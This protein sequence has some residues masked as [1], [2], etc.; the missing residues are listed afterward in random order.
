MKRLV[1]HTRLVFGYP[2]RI[3]ALALLSTWGLFL[4]ACPEQQVRAPR[5][6]NG[7]VE[8]REECDDGNAVGGDGCSAYCTKEGGEICGNYED[9][10]HDGLADCADPDCQGNPVCF[11]PLENCH[12]SADDDDDGLID[13]DDP[14]C[15]QTSFC[16]PDED[17]TNGIDDDGNGLTDCQEPDC[18]KLPLCGAC[19][20]VKDLGGLE[21]GDATTVSLDPA[22]ALA[23]PALDC[24]PAG[25]LEMQVRLSL[26]V[27]AHLL[28]SGRIRADEAVGIVQEVAPD[29]SCVMLQWGC[30]QAD[31]QGDVDLA[32]Y[33]LP[34][35][36]YR[37]AYRPTADATGAVSVHLLL[38][39]GDVEASCSDGRDEDADGLT[40]CDDPDCSGDQACVVEVCD[41][42]IDDDSDGQTDCDDSDCVMDPACLPDEV[43]GNGI[44]D[45][46]DG[47]TD[48]ADL[49]CAGTE[50]CRGGLC[51]VNRHLGN[52]ERGDEV[53]WSFDTTVASDLAVL[54][55]GGGREVVADMVLQTRSVV[56]FHLEQT[57]YH[58]LALTTESGPEHW[59]N[60]AEIDCIDPR[61]TGLDIDT[62]Y[63]LPPAKYFLFVEALSEDA[64]GQ[65]SVTV[66]VLGG[67]GEVCDDGIDDDSDG[68]TDCDDPDCSGDVACLPESVCHD[69]VD[70]DLDGWTDCAD[71]DCVG[72]PA[73]QGDDCVADRDLGL[74]PVGQPVYVTDST[75]GLSDRYRATCNPWSGPDRVFSFE[76][77]RSGVVTLRL[78]QAMSSD[79][80]LVLAFEGGPGSAC[81]DWPHICAASS[82]PGLPVV[83]RSDVL[84]AG[85]YEVLVDAWG[86]QGAGPFS[87]QVAFE[88]VSR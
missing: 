30:G 79:H 85:H 50:G 31:A 18:A 5:C 22:Q 47:R 40:D 24:G 82:G 65:G 81:V 77:D 80:G 49:D 78:S 45:D 26:A 35:G 13:C 71:V 84:P 36:T 61:G 51:V 75:D 6:G 54:S 69:G 86:E 39:D 38:L 29:E 10:D 66:R 48:C 58:V 8:G 70:D 83:V 63:L 9:D 3:W 27:S 88:D 34:P 14:D 76:L 56:R 68:M 67:L 25:S 43:C 60:E 2:L 53:L 55:C 21:P 46:A 33:R 17:C 41:N 44:D 52:L 4:A 64:T 23:S 19:D 59:C 28:L 15:A 74:L 1:C 12:N 73:C 7:V 32:W 72:N 57:G 11:E 87:L 16:L 42:G 62:A 37:L 20:F